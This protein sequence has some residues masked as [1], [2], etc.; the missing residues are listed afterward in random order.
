MDVVELGDGMEE[1]RERG[2]LR[3][4]EVGGVEPLEGMEEVA[5]ED[6][7]VEFVVE[8]DVGEGIVERG[9]GFLEVFKEWGPVV[10]V[11]ALAAGIGEGEG[12]AGV[13][14]DDFGAAVF[15]EEGE[16]EDGGRRVKG[17]I[18]GEP[19]LD[20]AATPIEGEVGAGDVAIV[21]GEGS[22][23][24][25]FA[26]GVCAGELGVFDGIDEGVVNLD[27]L[28][29]KDNGLGDGGGLKICHWATRDSV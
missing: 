4:E 13:V 29:G 27:G 16:F 25:V 2:I 23:G 12:D 21:G 26:G 24:A 8:V 10:L 9:L 18:G 17:P 22:A 28:G 6:H 1:G 3:G 20:D 5:G 15:V 19:V 14:H 7:A 11:P